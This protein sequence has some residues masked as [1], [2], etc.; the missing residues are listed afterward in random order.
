MSL[1]QRVQA[2][3]LYLRSSDWNLFTGMHPLLMQLIPRTWNKRRGDSSTPQQEPRRRQH[4]YGYCPK[5]SVEHLGGDP[6]HWPGEGF[7]SCNVVHPPFLGV[8][9]NALVFPLPSKAIL[10]RVNYVLR[11][12]AHLYHLA[13]NSATRARLLFIAAEL[14]WSLILNWHFV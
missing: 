7:F 4:W 10:S 9:V 8:M 5:V 3:I 2:A 12:D 13:Q 6:K 14:S 1:A 11:I